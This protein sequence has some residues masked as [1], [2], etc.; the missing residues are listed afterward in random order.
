[1][2][3]SLPLTS[4]PVFSFLAQDDAQKL[5]A[6]AKTLTKARGEAVVLANEP[7]SG[8]FILAEGQCGVYPHGSTTALLTLNPGEVFGEMSFLEKSRGSATI[9]AESPITRLVVMSHVDLER[10]INGDPQV[11]RNL[12]RGFALALSRKLRHT[13]E[14]IAGE[15]GERKKLMLSLSKKTHE[16]LTFDEL[17]KSLDKAVE[18]VRGA[19]VGASSRVDLLAK[20]FPERSGSFAE[21]SLD[22]GAAKSALVQ[23]QQAADQVKLLLQFVETMEKLLLETRQ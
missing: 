12:Y 22:L 7:V 23:L 2:A 3:I 19:T 10:L 4:I 20:S 15:L 9:R 6:I 16:E 13:T 8:I 1:M 11:G 21:I 14:R 17:H 5:A 18:A